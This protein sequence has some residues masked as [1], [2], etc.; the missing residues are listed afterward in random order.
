MNDGSAVAAG[1]A[2][3]VAS[4]VTATTLAVQQRLCQCWP[5]EVR[6][7]SIFERN[8]S[9]GKGRPGKAVGKS[10]ATRLWGWPELMETATV[11]GD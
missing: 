2:V 11:K 5:P 4:V 9:G 8:V 3:A 7:W 1:R 10:R 6:A